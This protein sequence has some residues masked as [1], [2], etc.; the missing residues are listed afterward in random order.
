MN[1]THQ[2]ACAPEL[3]EIERAFELDYAKLPFNLEHF[4]RSHIM[5]RYLRDERTPSQ[6]LRLRRED[7]R[8]YV[9]RKSGEAM[10]RSE[11]EIALSP[12]E[13]SKLWDSA[14]SEE[15]IVKTRTKVPW[16][17]YLLHIDEFTRPADE[18]MRVEIEFESVGAANSFVPPEWFGKEITHDASRKNSEL[19]LKLRQAAFSSP[20]CSPLSPLRL[21]KEEG[22]PHA[23]E[24]LTEILRLAPSPVIVG[25]SGGSASGKTSQVARKIMDH[26]GERALIISLD[27]YSKGASYVQERQ[28]QGSEINWDHPEYIDLDLAA[29]HLRELK[30]GTPD[31]EKPVFSFKTG[32]RMESER[33]ASAPLIIVE[34]LFALRPE[35]QELIDYRIFV[36]VG[37]HGRLI[38]RLLRDAERTKMSAEAIMNY[39][40]ETVHP[41]HHK[42][43]APLAAHADLIIDNDYRPARE[44]SRITSRDF[45]IKFES[46]LSEAQ[47]QALGAALLYRREQSDTYF[48]ASGDETLRIRKEDQKVTFT[49]KGA[50][51]EAPLMRATFQAS[52]SLD[53]E[54]KLAK[55]YPGKQLKVSKHR[56]AYQ[57]QQCLVCI[58]TDITVE[59]GGTTYRLPDHVEI[60]AS[61]SEAITKA[62]LHSLS[63][64][65]CKG[66]IC[67]YASL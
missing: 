5:Q 67:A 25:I 55:Y 1:P 12:E 21:S 59:R 42:Y 27:D 33:I 63:L 23:I 49:Y 47:L 9:T 16:G 51:A 44:A 53:L 62:L 56:S 45:Q 2:L 66:K 57:L 20:P 38:R 58:D 31:I 8:L 65:A 17:K 50:S 52:A 19:A 15:E 48:I 30:R 36:E 46:S 11:K 24:K 61:S 39:T 64:D 6:P 18:G 3:R 26:F 32:E 43:I 10:D 35:L 60:Q 13:F 28:Q 14:P 54:E 37:A 7:S 22:L 41:M 40:I 34:G 4:P 29:L